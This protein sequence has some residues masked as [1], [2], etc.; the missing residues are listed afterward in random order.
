MNNH[1]NLHKIQTVELHSEEV[2]YLII[3]NHITILAPDSLSQETIDLFYE[4]V[5]QTDILDEEVA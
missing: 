4:L 1:N 5:E 3:D 2:R